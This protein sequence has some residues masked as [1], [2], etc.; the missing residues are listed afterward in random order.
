M[1]MKVYK[2]GMRIAV[3]RMTFIN[4]TKR[5][6]IQKVKYLRNDSTKAVESFTYNI[7]IETHDRNLW[8]T[9]F[10]ATFKRLKFWN[11]FKKYEKKNHFYFVKS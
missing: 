2:D 3:K 4:L 5:N 7:H 1:C 8:F 9:K 6:S 10:H 11:Q